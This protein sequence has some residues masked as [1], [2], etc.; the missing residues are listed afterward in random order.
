MALRTGT[1]FLASL[2]DRR[3]IWLGGEWVPDVAAHPSLAGCAQSLAD[4]YDLLRNPAHRDLL[5]MEL[6]QTAEPVS[7]AYLLPQTPEDLV[8][9]RRMAEYLMRRTGGVAARLPAHMA[10]LLIGLYDARDILADA[11]PVFAENAARYFADCRGNDPCIAPG[12][13][14]PP[15]DRSLPPDRF[16][17]FRVVERKPDGI[18]VRGVKAVST[19]APYADE[20]LGLTAPRPHLAPT[21]VI[22]FAT[23]INTQGIRIVCRAPLAHPAHPDHPLSG[24]YDEMDAWLVFDD[25][26]IP[27]DRVFY[28]QSPERNEELF[29]RLL[30]WAS[31]DDLIRMAAKAEV[32]A[33]ICVAITDYL[34]TAKHPQTEASLAEAISY[35]ATLRAFVL[36]AEREAIVT[37]GGLLAPNPVQVLLGRIHGVG[38][39]PAILQ[40]LREL[41]GSGLLMAP[42]EA[43]MTDP[44]IRSD[45][46]RYLV[47]PDAQAPDRFRL[48]KLA[49]EYA[50]DAFGSRQLLFEM[51]NQSTLAVN[52][53]RLLNA[54]D[55]APLAKLAK[56][57]AGIEDPG[58]TI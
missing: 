23:P 55:T 31:Y 39:H 11:D 18:V 37:P 21:E 49:W 53:T 41:C 34:G 17:S 48:L 20:F 8:R 52:R 58:F 13:S 16:E 45:V 25:V 42:G 46:D 56:S 36:G 3:Q 24:H 57:L 9:R 7:L 32:I 5:T 1:A 2:Q 33:G 12:F 44:E 10:T 54:Y 30:L 47:G 50:G 26:F 43:E 4:V 51:H 38:H 22:Y 40:T 14:E 15:R 35:A 29:G 6:P 28:L 19:L 27:M